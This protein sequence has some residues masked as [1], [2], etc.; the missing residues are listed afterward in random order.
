MLVEQKKL[1]AEA[2]V[3]A[4]DE[5][6]ESPLEENTRYVA[7]RKETLAPILE[8][9]EVI[10]KQLYDISKGI[11]EEAAKTYN[12]AATAD[13]LELLNEKGE[14]NIGV[15]NNLLLQNK[16]ELQSNKYVVDHGLDTEPATLSIFLEFQ[17]DE[18]FK[19]VLRKDVAF[20]PDHM[21]GKIKHQKSNKEGQ[22]NIGPAVNTM[23]VYSLFHKY[24]VKLSEGNEIRIN[25]KDYFTYENTTTDAV[26]KDGKKTR[27]FNMISQVITAMTDNAKERI[28]YKHNLT[29]DSIPVFVHMVALGIDEKLAQA[30]LLHPSVFEYYAEI[31]ENKL[32]VKDLAALKSKKDIREGLLTKY[33]AKER[34]GFDYDTETIYES[35]NKPLNP[36]T[37]SYMLK[38]LF[39]LEDQIAPFN[40]VLSL[41]K[42]PKGL[43][44]GMTTFRNIDESLTALQLQE[45]I[46]TRSL[47]DDENEPI[48]WEGIDTAFE[49]HYTGQM[50]N[51]AKE[52]G[53]MSKQISIPLTS[54]F[55]KLMRSVYKQADVKNYNKE[56][57]Y[58]NLINDFLSFLSASVYM[59]MKEGKPVHGLLNPSVLVGENSLG[60][61]LPLAEQQYK[62]I[63]PGQESALLGEYLTVSPVTLTQTVNG[64]E[65]EIENSANRSGF[66]V[67]KSNTFTNID[68]NESLKLQN[69]YENMLNSGDPILMKTAMAIYAYAIV[70]DGHM[71][72]S[73]GLLQIL[74]TRVLKEFM[75]TL[76]LVK[77][78]FVK[79]EGV[80]DLKKL[81]KNSEELFKQHFGDT[82]LSLTRR[83][84]QMYFENF[85]NRDSIKKV[86]A[87]KDDSLTVTKIPGGFTVDLFKGVKNRELTADE[88]YVMKKHGLKPS[89]FPAN[90]FKTEFGKRLAELKDKGFQIYAVEENG[91][92]RWKISLPLVVKTIYRTQTENTTT[93]YRLKTINP[94]QS[95]IFEN[96]YSNDFNILSEIGEYEAFELKGGYNLSSISEMFGELPQSIKK[97]TKQALSEDADDRLEAYL[98]NDAINQGFA[99]ESDFSESNPIES[100]LIQRMFKASG[101]PEQSVKMQISQPILVTPVT[102]IP[103]SDRLTAAMQTATTKALDE[104]LGE[105]SS[106]YLDLP[107]GLSV[108]EQDKIID[109]LFGKKI[110]PKLREE[111]EQKY[112]QDI[113]TEED[114]K[115]AE[116]A[117][118]NYPGWSVY[119]DFGDSTVKEI[120]SNAIARATTL[121]QDNTELEGS[122]FEELMD[123]YKNGKIDDY[124]EQAEEVLKKYS[125]FG[126]L[127]Y[128]PNQLS[129]FELPD[130]KTTPKDGCI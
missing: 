102:S 112:V 80:Q 98:Q 129:L 1:L 120:K 97:K 57:F 21:L 78:I 27:I 96:Y 67:V 95:T 91:K 90:F 105:D 9:L 65:V 22:E 74:P 18:Y 86:T 117:E 50:I 72:K 44:N 37:E 33:P 14:Q 82:F 128:N 26:R 2:E 124:K 41:V 61:L 127:D 85:N 64:Q 123:N 83:F 101:K 94:N 16:I 126:L 115:K 60:M 49:Q 3:L 20:F 13:E 116:I 125:L 46:T 36:N 84:S 88:E 39:Q 109:V 6:D 47:F 70:K 59:K 106:Y 68:E 75:N 30:L 32:A 23:L 43:Y 99:S 40:D 107:I 11:K 51:Q 25:G 31:R 34:Q 73:G 100:D 71:F 89:A 7:E 8:R 122:S 87:L 38:L 130:I 28:A 92:K 62:V 76:T 63:Y 93:Y 55:E 42:L 24:G 58:K 66:D 17:Q 52:L 54:I 111:Y 104:Y 56:V 48:A 69:E 45:P 4:L 5:E 53:V 110:D 10:R 103:S 119:D 121:Y 118:Q 108:E 79:N 29:L 35:L 81:N 15:L 19:K 77:D 113:L 114:I 12:I